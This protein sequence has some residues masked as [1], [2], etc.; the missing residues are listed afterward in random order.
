MRP[1][2]V[3]LRCASLRSRTG[4]TFLCDHVVATLLVS[5][6]VHAGG[7]SP[8]KGWYMQ[9]VELARRAMRNWRL[10]VTSPF[11]RSGACEENDEH[12]V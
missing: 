10:R 6:K 12:Q 4:G 11:S 9:T 2:T 5:L 1:R 3:F 7:R 8:P